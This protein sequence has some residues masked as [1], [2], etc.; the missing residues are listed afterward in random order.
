MVYTYGI[1]QRLQNTKEYLL[2]K[3][4]NKGT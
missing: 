1:H 2:I 4:G 3:R